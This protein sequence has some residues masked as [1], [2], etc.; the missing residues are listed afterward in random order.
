MSESMRSAILVVAGAIVGGI[1]MVLEMDG[2]RKDFG[3]KPPPR[4]GENWGSFSGAPKAELLDD[5][6]QLRLL[7]DFA[8]VDPRNKA[9]VAPKGA[10]VDGASIPRALFSIV[11][12]PL[13]GQYRNASIV[14]D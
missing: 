12:G 8:Y 6:R 7:E 3:K 2:G 5:G 4:S 1:G 13:E 11:G 10:V 14:H 9:W